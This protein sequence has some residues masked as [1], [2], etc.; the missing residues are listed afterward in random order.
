[1]FVRKC[2]C[3]YKKTVKPFK[4]KSNCY[5]CPECGAKIETWDL[6]YLLVISVVCILIYGDIPYKAPIVMGFLLYSSL[7]NFISPLWLPLGI[8]EKP[9]NKN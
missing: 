2:P 5:D 3:C 6:S 4:F 7:Q 1:M 8:K 9:I